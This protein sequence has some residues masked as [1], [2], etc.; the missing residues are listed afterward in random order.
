MTG[1]V[2]FSVPMFDSATT[3][4]TL[5]AGAAFMLSNESSSLSALSKVDG[6]LLWAAFVPAGEF[7]D[8]TAW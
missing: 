6:S 5:L 7:S 8:I 1:G 3:T 4:P 2:I